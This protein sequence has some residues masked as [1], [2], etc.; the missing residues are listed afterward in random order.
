MKR[1]TAIALL[2][3]ATLSAGSVPAFAVAPPGACPPGG[4]WE[5]TAPGPGGVQVDANGDGLICALQ[6]RHP[7]RVGFLYNLV[8]NR[9][10]TP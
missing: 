8:D 4:G 6:Y 2:G 3:A 5:L 10:Q 1:R 7:E 9:V